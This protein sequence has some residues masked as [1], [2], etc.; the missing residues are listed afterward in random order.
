M[1][2]KELRM[3]FRAYNYVIESDFDLQLPLINVETTVDVVFRQ[4]E[5]K[6]SKTK[7]T[8]IHRKGIV[9]EASIS[10][11]ILTLN[12][13]NIGCFQCRG[14]DIIYEKLTTGDDIFRLFAVSEVLGLFL[15]QKGVFLLHGSSVKVGNEAI[16]FIGKPG[17]GKSTTVA[18]FAKAGFSVLSDDM[19][20]ICFDE[21]GFP[22][23]LPAYP[24][25]KIWEE[26]VLKLGFEKEKLEPA[27][28]GHNKFLLRQSEVDF[29]K[30]AVKLKEIVVLQ[31]PNSLKN[32]VITAHQ[33]P[34][35]LVKYFPLPHQFLKGTFLQNH[36]NSSLKIASEIVVRNMKRPQ[37]FEALNNLIPSFQTHEIHTRTRNTC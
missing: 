1:T 26:S 29:P 4:K 12:W 7:R 18:A 8:K 13:E 2:L 16:V 9:A 37:N 20:G 22:V 34:I 3:L 19:T 27:Y 15:F 17:A 25:I 14:N 21:N 31:K 11:S 30:E 5:I 32:D 33:I 36:F 35:E 10:D 28:E 23:V 24:T 6:K